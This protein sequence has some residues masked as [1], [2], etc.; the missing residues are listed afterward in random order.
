MRKG[1]IDHH[2]FASTMNVTRSN[3]WASSSAECPTIGMVPE[4][5]GSLLL[6]LVHF[7]RVFKCDRHI[8]PNEN[9]TK[10]KTKPTWKHFCLKYVSP[11]QISQILRMSGPGT[12]PLTARSKR[13]FNLRRTGGPIAA[14]GG[15]GG[16]GRSQ[17]C[18]IETRNGE[19][20]QKRGRRWKKKTKG[21]FFGRKL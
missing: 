18:T 11:T 12:T 10:E 2:T 19:D 3:P 20:E 7:G 21:L 8:P 16:K 15:N 17:F 9:Y 14:V 13:N 5:L 6:G 4:P 1:V